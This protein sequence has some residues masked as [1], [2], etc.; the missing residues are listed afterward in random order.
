[1]NKK[2]I[3]LSL[4]L[5]A[6]IAI[7]FFISN[8]QSQKNQKKLDNFNTE[9]I[10]IW[11]TYNYQDFNDYPERVRPYLN[12]EKFDFYFSNKESLEIRKGRMVTSNYSIA[13][14]VEKIISRGKSGKNYNYQ[15]E[16]KE[17]VSSNKESYE[18]TKTILVSIQ[19]ED[20]RLKVTNVEY[21][22]VE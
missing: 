20:N 16:V 6:F 10:E 17:T 12:E 13:T 3:I 21:L 14:K 7:S 9:F 4:S 11:G 5:V 15:S 18:K 19:E 1:M 8:Y 2:V 22:G